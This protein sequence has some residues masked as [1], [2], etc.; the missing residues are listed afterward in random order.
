MRSKI[1]FRTLC[2]K[3]IRPNRRKMSNSVTL[4]K[5]KTGSFEAPKHWLQRRKP[6]RQFPAF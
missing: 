1:S 6:E 3:N 4:I 2:S 5:A